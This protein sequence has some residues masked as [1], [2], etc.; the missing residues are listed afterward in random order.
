MAND[1]NS[2]LGKFG[3][4]IEM[5]ELFKRNRNP[6]AEN[7]VKEVHKEIN[8]AGYVNNKPKSPWQLR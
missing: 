2:W 6:I 8:N 1:P 3:I 7:L 4:E 5:G